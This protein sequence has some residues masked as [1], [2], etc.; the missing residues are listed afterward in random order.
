MTDAQLVRMVVLNV[1]PIFMCD[2]IHGEDDC[3]TSVQ[4]LCNLFS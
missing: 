2:M 1:M 3:T 4:K